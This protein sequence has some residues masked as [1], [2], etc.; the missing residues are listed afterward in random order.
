M[1]KYLNFTV[2]K[3]S[4]H[5]RKI[6]YKLEQSETNKDSSILK[7]DTFKNN[8][9]RILEIDIIFRSYWIKDSSLLLTKGII[10]SSKFKI[11]ILESVVENIELHGMRTNCILFTW[12]QK[13]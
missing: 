9:F 4:I 6:K 1:I 12:M 11:W 3:I 5:G 13:K 10:R 2:K 7:I 8:N